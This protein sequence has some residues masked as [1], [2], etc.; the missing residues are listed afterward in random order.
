M[1]PILNTTNMYK[2]K[3]YHLT[4]NINNKIRTRDGKND[5]HTINISLCLY[6]GNEGVYKEMK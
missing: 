6:A 2:L 3:D 5:E 1:T 4:V